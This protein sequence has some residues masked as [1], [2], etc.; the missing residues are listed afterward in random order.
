MGAD[1]IRE[2]NCYLVQEMKFTEL[3]KDLRCNHCYN[4]FEKTDPASFEPKR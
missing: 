1:V 4:R 2:L 3:L